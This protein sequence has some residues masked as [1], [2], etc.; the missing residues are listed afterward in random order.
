ML[1]WDLS[2]APLPIETGGT[3]ASLLPQSN[4]PDSATPQEDS[5]LLLD[6]NCAVDCAEPVAGHA[7]DTPAL[8][9]QATEPALNSGTKAVALSG[10]SKKAKKTI[11]TLHEDIIRESFWKKHPDVLV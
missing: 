11:V 2:P 1:I 6:K 5:D 7:M 9:S 4:E 3:D 8:N 10:R